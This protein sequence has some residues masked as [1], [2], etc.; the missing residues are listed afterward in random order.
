M[1]RI[2]VGILLLGFA[3]GAL[4]GCAPTRSG[5]MNS[6]EQKQI[7]PRPPDQHSFDGLGFPEYELTGKAYITLDDGTEVRAD[8]P[9]VSVRKGDSVTVQQN[10]D[11][12][13]V[14]LRKN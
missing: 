12:S 4:F 6:Y 5:T 14:V 8:C 13:W 11:G 9:I 10:P 7:G 1:K 3:F 2:F